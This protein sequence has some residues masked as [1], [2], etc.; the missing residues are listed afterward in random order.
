MV[1]VKVIVLTLVVGTVAGVS[2]KCGE[3]IMVSRGQKKVLKFWSSEDEF[4]NV[5]VIPMR[6]GV[7]V[8][9]KEGG[10][11]G[12]KEK[13]R[14]GATTAKPPS[15]TTTTNPPSS[16]SAFNTEGQRKD[17]AL[18]EQSQGDLYY[19]VGAQ[20]TPQPPSTTQTLQTEGDVASHTHQNKS[21]ESSERTQPSEG[22]GVNTVFLEDSIVY[23]YKTEDDYA[24]AADDSE[25]SISLQQG[26]LADDASIAG[27]HYEQ[28]GDLGDHQT[29][30]GQLDKGGHR[31]QQ[32]IST[33][34]LPP[35]TAFD[36]LS[37]SQSSE[38]EK[39]RDGEVDDVTT[40]N[41]E[42]QGEE[43][44]VHPPVEMEIPGSL[45]D[46]DT[47]L[48]DMS[49]T[50]D[51]EVTDA[52]TNA[53][54]LS[55]S[56]EITTVVPERAEFSTDAVVDKDDPTLPLGERGQVTEDPNIFTPT[57]T[58]ESSTNRIY[59]DSPEDTTDI[60][61]KDD[62]E[63]QIVTEASIKEPGDDETISGDKE[64]T[65]DEG[66][67]EWASIVSRQPTVTPNT[68]G[69]EGMNLQVDSMA[70]S[71]DGTIQEQGDTTESP[72]ASNDRRKQPPTIHA[73][74]KRK[75]TPEANEDEIPGVLVDDA[76]AKFT[77]GSTRNEILI[78]EELLQKTTPEV[79]TEDVN[80]LAVAG[81]LQEDG[82]SEEDSRTTTIIPTTEDIASSSEEME[83]KVKSDESQTGE[84]EDSM[85]DV[86]TLK[87]PTDLQITNEIIPEGGSNVENALERSDIIY[88]SEEKFS[89]SDS[90]ESSE[91]NSIFK[92]SSTE[93]SET[94][95]N[96]ERSEDTTESSNESNSI[97][98]S[99]DYDTTEIFETFGTTERS[100]ASDTTER[101]DLLEATQ[102]SAVDDTLYR[103]EI[104]EVTEK[105]EEFDITEKS[106]VLP[107]TEVS[108]V[109]DTTERSKVPE[110]TERSEILSITE[111]P[112]VIE[113]TV[114]SDITEA[115]EILDEK[116]KPNVL[117]T[118]VETS[119]NTERSDIPDTT[120]RL[121][122]SDT[123]EEQEVFDTKE[124]SDLS[125][126]TEESDFFDEELTTEYPVNVDQE[127]V[128][129]K[130]ST[131]K[132]DSH[133]LISTREGAEDTTER[134]VS[135]TEDNLEMRVDDITT[136]SDGIITQERDEGPHNHI[137]S[138]D[139][140]YDYYN[141]YI[142]HSIDESEGEFNPYL[143]TI[144]YD[145]TIEYDG[146]T[147]TTA[148]NVQDG[149]RTGQSTLSPM[150]LQVEVMKEEGEGI[151]AVTDADAASDESRNETAVTTQQTT[152]AGGF[153]INEVEE[154][155]RAETST[156]DN[157]EALDLTTVRTTDMFSEDD[158][159]ANDSVSL[160]NAGDDKEPVKNSA[161]QETSGA[162]DGSLTDSLFNDIID[163]L[164]SALENAPEEIQV[165]VGDF[166]IN[167]QDLFDIGGKRNNSEDI[168]ANLTSA[169]FPVEHRDEATLTRSDTVEDEAQVE[170]TTEVE[171]AF[172]LEDKGPDTVL[173]TDSISMAG[174]M[175]HSMMEMTTTPTPTDGTTGAVMY[176][177]P[178]VTD[179]DG[180]KGYDYY[181]SL[182]D[183]LMAQDRPYDQSESKQTV[184]PTTDEG[185]EATVPTVT[186]SSQQK[187]VY[188]TLEF[189]MDDMKST[190]E[191]EPP[192]TVTVS[193]MEMTS[194]N[195]ISESDGLEITTMPFKAKHDGTENITESSFDD[196]SE[197]SSLESA[198]ETTTVF[199]IPYLI[200]QNQAMLDEILNNQKLAGSSSVIIKEQGSKVAISSPTQDET[201]RI[202]EV[203]DNNT[204][205]KYT[206][207]LSFPDNDDMS[208]E[209]IQ[210]V[211]EVI[212]T[213]KPN[214]VTDKPDIQ[215][216]KPNIADSLEALIDKL[217]ELAGN[218]VKNVTIKPENT[219][220]TN[221]SVDNI[222]I[223]NTMGVGSD[224][225]SQNITTS[226]PDELSERMETVTDRPNM[227]TDKEDFST[228]KPDVGTTRPKIMNATE[229]PSAVSIEP[230][231]REEPTEYFWNY[232]S[233]NTKTNGHQED[234]NSP[235]A[236]NSED[237]KSAV[238]SSEDSSQDSETPREAKPSEVLINDNEATSTTTEAII[239][240]TTSE[241]ELAT[242]LLPS[243][244]IDRLGEVS[245]DR[246]RE[247]PTAIE[248]RPPNHFDIPGI[249][250]RKDD[251]G[252]TEYGGDSPFFI[253]LPGSPNAVPVY[254]QYEP[255]EVKYVPLKHENETDG[256]AVH[257]NI[258][259]RDP[260]T[261]E[262]EGSDYEYYENPEAAK[263]TDRESQVAK[264][265]ETD[266]I[267]L[268][269]DA[270]VAESS[271]SETL[272]VNEQ[273][274]EN[275]L[276]NGIY[277][278]LD[279]VAGPV[280]NQ[281]PQNTQVNQEGPN[282]KPNRPVV[283]TPDPFFLME[284]PK[285]GGSS[286]GSHASDDASHP[287]HSFQGHSTGFSV[288]VSSH[289]GFESSKPGNQGVRTGTVED[290]PISIKQDVL[291][292]GD[293]YKHDAYTG[294]NLSELTNPVFNLRT[295]ATTPSAED[296]KTPQYTPFPITTNP[297]RTTT[298]FAPLSALPLS[299]SF[300]S[301]EKDKHFDNAPDY[302]I[303]TVNTTT[304]RTMSKKPPPSVEYSPIPSIDFA[305][306]YESP[307]IP[308]TLYDRDRP[309]PLSIEE[310]SRDQ[311][312]ESSYDRA[313]PESYN[314]GFSAAPFKT[315]NAQGLNIPP[316]KAPEGVVTPASLGQVLVDAN[317]DEV[318][319]ENQPPPSKPFTAHDQSREEPG[320][321]L[322]DS[323]GRVYSAFYSPHDVPGID[324]TLFSYRKVSGATPVASDPFGQIP[325][326]PFEDSAVRSVFGSEDLPS[327]SSKTEDDV[328]FRPQFF[329]YLNTLP[330]ALLRKFLDPNAPPDTERLKRSAPREGE[331]IFC[332]WNIKTEPGLYLLMTFHNLS[333]AYTVDC[334]GAYIEV[335]RENNGY[336][337]RWCGNRVSLA[338]SR[339]HV[340]FAKSEVRI[341]VY[342]DGS[343]NKAL[344]TGFEA[345][346]EVIDLFD[347]QEYK[348]FMRSNAY[349]H[350]RRLLLG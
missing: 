113:V 107:P 34:V 290:V 335:E 237:T 150:D 193:S 93:V 245:K 332:E 169:E 98:K 221:E 232:V 292:P 120:E 227:I 8:G 264:P 18:V 97:K 261:Y 32:I 211:T 322:H 275:S 69:E 267:S 29:S 294:V 235:G 74:T 21:K 339:P 33:Q 288:D 90:K 4:L 38:T 248:A 72:L 152:M 24:D 53:P 94:L 25:N 308:E 309:F 71:T 16:P 130:N 190:D 268:G 348:A 215:I 64:Q 99:E 195:R 183:S 170:T 106:D 73:D 323:T 260:V 270:T 46:T 305:D 10:Q 26:S 281:Y 262:N 86:T 341:T 144:D 124:R 2:L 81:F 61:L 269:S 226:K 344:P 327:P 304:E 331:Q 320:L 129:R 17:P 278:I 175:D 224:S 156:S 244:F 258:N 223:P 181:E 271:S 119:D 136:V 80:E 63:G 199:S 37:A 299:T 123:T 196:A 184:S 30:V 336:D 254:I 208:E 47:D 121:E 174:F 350:I 277:R 68:P 78:P 79:T 155:E 15:S 41:Q 286:D 5:D 311:T 314:N 164:T 210:D 295:K 242:I 287:T 217:E 31:D 349:P 111:T 300:L 7:K 176:D 116:E 157:T 92:E 200:L 238:S 27:T 194:Q 76:P 319:Q 239:S 52:T 19:S 118:M 203:T 185:D 70:S 321:G 148:G 222:I 229:L 285:L 274:Q 82:T 117:D 112:E 135:E 255:V 346:I 132:D 256:D 191:P 241:P 340:I 206:T 108:A 40:E 163:S 9:G 243:S 343:A 236:N 12:G 43:T 188:P 42:S 212:Q 44:T 11:T 342:D 204:D 182:V 198:V 347:P 289:F 22:L 312:D 160:M 48:E 115:S 59:G 317:G 189:S 83:S 214:N 173:E 279:D 50:T 158:F 179:E 266:E 104:L 85:D 101:S 293:Y 128:V 334:H 276:L 202:Q 87:Y 56:E 84:S 218:I 178:D 105:P 153:K 149:E 283:K 272:G 147:Q 89:T 57:E 62:G 20:V 326:R 220:K 302:A 337:A 143:D 310:Y 257:D 247:Q 187:Y 273:T 297:P 325:P 1:G 246:E 55:R 127:S 103:S 303:D 240:S 114:R 186:S 296:L 280:S 306:S 216:K 225:N 171:S 88:G 168:N 28:K 249:F 330:Y 324:P 192:T 154:V 333:A 298:T 165:P 140:D 102:N 54:Q 301:P 146:I 167:I 234:H 109:A 159:P 3:D 137:F 201:S 45:K 65:M 95:N 284:A 35:L 315:S 316:N 91:E 125:D 180:F 318:V 145:D 231:I 139:N 142:H 253:K 205:N 151:V 213:I 49:D 345:D 230:A 23:D 126:T 66:V 252:Y 197:N 207:T 77:P 67:T 162:N 36:K 13:E 219:T 265:A 161:T 134:H 60:S 313:E 14:G 233:Q 75:D 6:G 209:P 250:S 259:Y 51:R 166:T 228:P 263:V 291:Y 338:G 110:S 131:E 133:N 282:F 307:F 141:H 58:T 39:E 100:E 122:A 177:Y 251:D 96:T 138:V 172:T 328:L 329:E